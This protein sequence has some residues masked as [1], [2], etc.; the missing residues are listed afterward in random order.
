MPMDV[1][2]PLSFRRLLE[3][4]IRDLTDRGYVSQQQIEDWLR[5]LRSAA[6]REL[7]PE[8][9]I[10]D[11]TRAALGAIYD[12]LIERG[13]VVEYV[14]GVSRYTLAMIKPRLRAELDRRILASADLIK[15]HRREA[16]EKTLQRF[17][18][19]STSIPPGGDGAINKREVRASV[20]KSVA[21]FKFEQR[22]VAID[23]GHK[24]IANMSNLVAVD[25]GAIAAEWNSHWRQAGYNY[26][27]DHKERD[28]K[29][30]A[31]RGS[32]AIDQGLINK[33]AGYLDEITQP[34]QE[35]FCRC[36]AR[37]VMS[38]RRLPDSMLTAK[39]RAWISNSGGKENARA[40]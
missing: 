32:W 2:A 11:M 28:G 27:K 36:F 6:E 33:G 15:L 16:V 31:V 13:R 21:Q 29:F 10:D 18:G 20:A 30:Y 7:G 12:R 14:P 35:P 40:A 38:P 37:Y 3:E 34:A 25:N 23:Q 5:V 22:R 4:A 17:S 26:R 39:G 9:R 8:G 24:L 1:P 19:W